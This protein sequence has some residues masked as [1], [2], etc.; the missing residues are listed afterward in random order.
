MVKGMGGYGFS[1]SADNIIVA[2]MHTN[3]K[4]KVNY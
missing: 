3:K 4:E 2:M 1:G